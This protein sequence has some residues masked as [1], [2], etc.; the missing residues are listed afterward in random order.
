[1]LFGKKKNTIFSNQIYKP[2][3]KTEKFFNKGTSEW[4]CPINHQVPPSPP[5][6]PW[7]LPSSLCWQPCE[8][9]ESV[10]APRRT[11]AASLPTIHVLFPTLYPAATGIFFL[12]QCKA[13]HDA[14]VYC[15]AQLSEEEKI[16]APSGLPAFATS[17]AMAPTLLQPGWAS[18]HTSNTALKPHI[19]TLVPLPPSHPHPPI[20]LGSNTASPGG[21]PQAPKGIRSYDMLSALFLYSTW[22][23]SV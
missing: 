22:W 12:K 4:D 18:R 19:H 5:L 16:N 7:Y 1:M 2:K 14:T 3:G 15:C 8:V 17:S 6:Y 21:L 9:Q 11:V 10:T 13:N 20:A 23:F